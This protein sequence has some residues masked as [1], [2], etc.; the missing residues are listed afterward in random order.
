MLR[1][2][3]YYTIIILFL[4]QCAYVKRRPELLEPIHQTQI[5]DI[6]VA[7]VLGGGGSKGFA[8]IGAIEVLEQN[9]IPIDL[10]VG[11]SAGSA[12]GAFYADNKNVHKTKEI[13]FKAKSNE[14]LDFSLSESLKMFTSL[15]SPVIGQSYEDYIF[16]NL[17]AITFSQ[18]KI[19]LVVV[20]VDAITGTKF[21]IKDGPIAPAIRAS[22]AIP[23]I[24]SPVQLYNK[25]LIDGGVLEPVPVATAKTYK[26]Q[27]IIAIDINNLPPKT[28]PNNMIE[29]T[30]R[31][32]WL[33]YYQLS[34]L[35]SA[36]ADI[37]IHPDLS[38]HGT[39]EDNRKEE[40][41]QLGRRA[42]LEALP[43]IKQKLK[44][45]NI[46]KLK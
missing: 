41:Y 28:K 13:L 4:T 9:N 16:N 19:P 12:V 5:K 7:L 46:H 29:L 11:T 26:P 44:N 20:T 43:Q 25:T 34:R 40:L 31:A 17:T 42:A 14:L 15:T 18:L 37:D 21:I 22:S 1:K 38:G 30:Y 36:Q 10:I 27:L 3:L 2:S 6:R 23:P 33:S 32:L 45:L 24:I 39:F 35:Q 8:H